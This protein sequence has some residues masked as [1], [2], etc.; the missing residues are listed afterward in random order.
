ME[1]GVSIPTNH[2]G[3]IRIIRKRISLDVPALTLWRAWTTRQGV[4]TFFAPQATVELRIGGPYEVYFN[5]DQPSGLRGSEG[6][7]I[8]SYLPEEMLSFEWNAPP[9]IPTLRTERIRG[10][11]WVVLQFKKTHAGGTDLSLSHVMPK[12][13]RDWQEYHEYFGSSWDIVLA[14]LALMLVNGPVDWT[15]PREELN[16]AALRE[17]QK[18]QTSGE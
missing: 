8:L 17:L 6:C 1:E 9:N 14:R 11:T 12:V 5:P 4:T 15:Q 10:Q 2:G 3:E 13:G 7:R 18:V 16:A